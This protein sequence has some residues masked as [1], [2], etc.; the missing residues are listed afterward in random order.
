[1]KAR[2]FWNGEPCK[3]RRVIVRVGLVPRPTW[4]CAALEG[5]ERDAVEITY[6]RK[7][8]FID[9]ENGEGWRKVT[10]GKGSPWTSHRSLP[11]G[12][13]VLREVRS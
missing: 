8:F 4:W 3:A 5:K 12:S 1:M 6:G 13:E 10:E 7:T 9:D 2:T 11:V